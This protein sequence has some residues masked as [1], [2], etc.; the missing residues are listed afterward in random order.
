MKPVTHV[1]VVDDDAPI[2]DFVKATLEG[3]GY[4]VITAENGSVALQLL[5]GPA[6]YQPDLILLDMRMPILDGWQFAKAYRDLPGK[7]VP[8]IVLTAATD[9]AKFAAQIKADNYL[10]KPF[11]LLDLLDMVEQFT[12]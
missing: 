3:E 9:P 10:P 5:T 1:L 6:S 11:D 12:H 8:I 2:R 7:K 4:A